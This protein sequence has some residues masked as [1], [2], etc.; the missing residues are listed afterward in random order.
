MS[1]SEALSFSLDDDTHDT[2]WRVSL[3]E[4]GALLELRALLS[5]PQNRGGAHVPST[6]TLLDIASYIVQRPNFV[7]ARP[8]V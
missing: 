5:E 6:E 1:H 2:V 8:V 4:K 7:Q 3:M